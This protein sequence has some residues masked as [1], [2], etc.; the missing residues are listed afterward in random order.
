MIKKGE[1]RMKKVSRHC[2]K[3]KPRC[4]WERGK[5]QRTE[6]LIL[7]KERKEKRNYDNQIKK[8]EGGAHLLPRE[9]N[10]WGGEA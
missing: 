1:K 8:R 9:G 3:R 4:A 6:L 5:G 7:Q 2:F 10:F